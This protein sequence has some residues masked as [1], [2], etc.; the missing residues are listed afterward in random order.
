MQDGDALS[1]S[2]DPYLPPAKKACTRSNVGALMKIN[3]QA[4]G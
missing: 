3:T 4:F 2:V 1:K